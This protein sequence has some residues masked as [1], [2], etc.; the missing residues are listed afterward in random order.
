MY[1]EEWRNLRR[2]WKIFIAASIV[3]F[4]LSVLILLYLETTG[5]SG[6][7]LVLI[8]FILMLPATILG[9]MVG[10]WKC[11]RCNKLFFMKWYW[12][13]IFSNKCLHCG[14]KKYAT[15]GD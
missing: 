12:S 8:F 15:S 13:N 2:K 4:I 7:T 11:P 9:W 10:L 5:M 1:E 3:G 6:G 14:L